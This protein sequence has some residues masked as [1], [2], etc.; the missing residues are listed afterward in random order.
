MFADFQGGDFAL[1][2]VGTEDD[3][4]GCGVLFDIDFVKFDAAVFEETFGAVAVR[5]PTGAVDCDG[6]HAGPLLLDKKITK[7]LQAEDGAAGLAEARRLQETDQ[8]TLT[9]APRYFLATWMRMRAR[10]NAMAARSQSTVASGE[11]MRFSARARA[12][13]ARSR[14][15]SSARSAVSA[16]MVTRSP[17]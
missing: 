4:F 11:A 2:V 17:N 7:R 14:S 16:R 15:I 6:F 9:G 10:C 8:G 1:A 13:C 12:A 5:A 3:G